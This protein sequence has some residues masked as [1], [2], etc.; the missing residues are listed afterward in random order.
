MARTIQEI[1]DSIIAEKEATTEL[2]GLTSTSSVA[3]WRLWCYVFA[4]AAWALENVLNI[5]IAQQ[6]A[7]IKEYKIHSFSWYSAF[8]KKFQ[9]GDALPYGEVEYEVIDE[10]KQVVKFASASK[11]PGG[12]VIKIA[13]LDGDTL[14]PIGGSEFT[15]FKE[16][17]FR[18]GAAG[19]RLTFVN[20]EPDKLK[21]ELTVYFDPLILNSSGGRLDGT[22]N[23]PVL[24]AIND[25]IKGID[26]DAKFVPTA[27]VDA[28]Q[29]VEGVDIPHIDLC[30]STYAALPWT[31]V[32]ANGIIPHAGYLR[33]YDEI[34]DLT[35]NYI[36]NN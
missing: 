3:I 23:T 32:P 9:Y 19:D 14:E 34:N 31:P 35:I 15:A 29:A 27:L 16:Y 4:V 2:A 25:Y 28:L 1:Y 21:L 30:E 22:N 12:I 20:D 17:M 5:S 8:A 13:G 10:D 33:I 26:F 18:V 24:D 36:A 6:T 11:A 7:F